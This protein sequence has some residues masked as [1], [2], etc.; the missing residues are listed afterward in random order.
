MLIDANV[1]QSLEA[2]TKKAGHICCLI[3]LANTSFEKYGTIQI[4]EDD[5]SKLKFL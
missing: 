3:K 4:F 2:N 1:G 5:S